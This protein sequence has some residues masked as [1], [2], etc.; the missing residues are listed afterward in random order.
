[1]SKYL[2]EQIYEKGWF[3]AF[4]DNPEKIP[5]NLRK[6]WYKMMEI[7][8]RMQPKIDKH[9]EKHPWSLFE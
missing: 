4:L 5:K 3:Q 8:D 6:D 1:M 2:I 7:T 9:L